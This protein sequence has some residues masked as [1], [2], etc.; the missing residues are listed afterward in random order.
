[1][2]RNDGYTAVAHTRQTDKPHVHVVAVSETKFNAKD[3]EQLRAVGDREQ[4]RILERDGL[5][6]AREKIALQVTN[7]VREQ[8]R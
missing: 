5:G 2:H 3:F 7:Q 4:A 8:A 1:M 6:M